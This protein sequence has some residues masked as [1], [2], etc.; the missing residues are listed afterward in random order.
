LVS[1][2]L[3]VPL[4]HTRGVPSTIDINSQIVAELVRLMAFGPG[5]AAVADEPGNSKP[6]AEG[7]PVGGV[8]KAI[9]WFVRGL[10]DETVLRI[11]FLVGA[12]GNGKSYWSGRA[13]AGSGLSNARASGAKKQSRSHEFL[14]VAGNV[15]MRIINDA[16]APN[17]QIDL[18]PTITDLASCLK[19]DMPVLVNINRGVF[20]R[21]IGQFQSVGASSE[22]LLAAAMLRALSGDVSVTNDITNLG[23]ISFRTSGSGSHETLMSLRIDRPGRLPVAA[24]AVQMDLHSVF[25]TP[26]QYGSDANFFDVPYT[27]HDAQGYEI[28]RPSNPNYLLANYWRSS[29][30]GHLLEAT[31]KLLASSGSQSLSDLNPIRSNIEQLCTEIFFSGITASLRSAELISSR[32][33]AFRHLWTAINLLV[34]GNLH[35]SDGSSPEEL[36]VAL[37]RRAGQLPKNPKDRLWEL[38]DLARFRFHQ[39]IYGAEWSVKNLLADLPHDSVVANSN[40]GSVREVMTICDPT[41]DSEKSVPT[42]AGER[43]WSRAIRDAFLGALTDTDAP[44]IVETAF[45]LTYPDREP[46]DLVCN[47]D[48][49]L[50]EA[51]LGVIRADQSENPIVSRGERDA[52]L[53]WY[54]DYLTRLVAA[55]LGLTAWARELEDFLKAWQEAQIQPQLSDDLHRKLMAYVLPTFEGSNEVN[56]RRLVTLLRSRTEPIRTSGDRPIIAYQLPTQIMSSAKTRGDRLVVELLDLQNIQQIGHS[57]SLF[58]LDLDVRLLRELNIREIAGEAYSD[59]SESILPLVERY[60]ALATTKVKTW[61]LITSSRVTK[62]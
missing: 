11:L 20:F 7:L 23:T 1:L 35:S 60:R 26:S 12:P 53:G 43:D 32:H 22:A 14:D 51:I 40:S 16:S 30:G 29:P 38:V 42:G 31:T 58:S 25:S 8:D 9:D 41:F 57:A 17:Q 34:V 24:V 2:P 39:A 15:K 46:A 13:A 49:A 27:R 33:F 28:T 55:S 10:G 4:W 62:V 37:D 44:S 19:S 5:G 18:T 61:S 6:P 59:V 48:R 36:L 45:K 47:F 54:G 21:E 56:P 50:D 3:L 52:I